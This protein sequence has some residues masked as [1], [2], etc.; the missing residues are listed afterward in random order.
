M[1]GRAPRLDVPGGRGR[2]VRWLVKE[3]EPYPQGAPL[4][5]V[6]TADDRVFD[7]TAGRAD[8]VLLEHRVPI[9]G[10]VVS[11]AAAAHVRISPT[12]ERFQ[13]TKRHHLRV[14][15]DWLLMPDRRADAV[16]CPAPANT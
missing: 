1:A 9:G 6:R 16:E 13:L 14:T 10:M 11:G 5:Q 12:V 4:A 7:L 8:G 3:G 15:G 2:L